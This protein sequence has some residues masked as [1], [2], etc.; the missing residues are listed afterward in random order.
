MTKSTPEIEKSGYPPFSCAQRCR[1]APNEVMLE[2]PGHLQNAS[3]RTLSKEQ[4]RGANHLLGHLHKFDV[5][6]HRHLAQKTIGRF[7]GKRF[8]FHQDSLCTLDVFAVGKL[9]L[10]ARKFVAQ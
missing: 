10:R 7:L 2:M 6:V 9:Q 3:L 1:G 4:L 5:L 8:L